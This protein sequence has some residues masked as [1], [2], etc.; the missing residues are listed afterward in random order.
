MKILLDAG[1]GAGKAHRRGATCYNEGDNNYYYSLVLKK[2]LESIKGVKVDLIRNRI[3]DNPSLSS[4]AAKGAGYDL[5]LSI[6]SNGANASVRG[7]EIWD[8]VQNPNKSLADKLVKEIADLFNH[9][10]RGTRY[11]KNSSGGNYYGVLR[12]NRAKSSMIIEHGFHSNSIDCQYFKNNHKSIAKATADIIKDHYKLAGKEVAKVDNKTLMQYGSRGKD[13][14]Q[15]QK[16]LKYLGYDVTVRG[17]YG[18][19]VKKAVEHF[20][21][22]HLGV[23]RSGEVDETTQRMIANDIKAVQFYKDNK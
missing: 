1:H 20:Q 7:S 18:K 11:R 23:R 2:E 5:F 8:N 13:V 9:P 19:E 3:T 14:I 10:N 12:G 4:R 17:G 15:L 22:R 6:H 21:S 16:D